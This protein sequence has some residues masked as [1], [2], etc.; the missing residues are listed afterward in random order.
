MSLKPTKG[1]SMRLQKLNLPF[2]FGLF[3]LLSAVQMTSAFYDPGFGRWLNRDP[4]GEPGFEVSH[5]RRESALGSGPNKYSF[6]GQS[7][8]NR[9]DAFG[10]APIPPNAEECY[11][12]HPLYPDDP[13]CDKYGSKKYLGASLRCFCKC[14]VLRDPW[15]LYVRGCL[16]C[17]EDKGVPVADAHAACYESADRNHPRP[18]S[19]LAACLCSCLQ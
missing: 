3:V 4:M 17:M 14:P 9:S 8:V 12:A 7:P 1:A 10:L 11:V 2:L 13:A 19:A 6:V 18:T 5:G 15:S 16:S